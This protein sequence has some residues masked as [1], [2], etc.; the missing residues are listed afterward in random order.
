MLSLVKGLDYEEATAMGLAGCALALSRKHFRR[1]SSLWDQR[2]SPGWLAAIALVLAG[3]TWLGFFAHKHVEYSSELWWRFEFSG[4]AP[5][6]LRASVGIAALVT[7][8]GL[9]RLFRTARHPPPTG[10]ADDINAALA[11]AACAPVTGANLVALG[12]KALLFSA[13]RRSFLMYGVTGRC[14]VALGDPIG[15]ADQAEELVWEFRERCDEAG[16]WTVF[17]EVSAARLPLYVDLGLSLFKLGEEARVPLTAFSL[18]GGARKGL[19]KTR[20]RVESEGCSFAVWEP[21]EVRSRLAELAVVSEAWLRQ[22]NTREKGFSLGFFDPAYVG[23]FPAGVVL[24]Q[25]CPVAFATLWRSGGK[26]ES[27]VD[28]MRHLPDAPAG[29]MDYLFIHLILLAKEE[30]FR[31]FNL[32]MAPFSG[33]EQ[34]PLAPFWNRMGALL[35]R[36]GEHFYNFRGLRQYKEKFDPVWEPKYLASPGGLILPRVLANIGALV[37]GGLSGLIRK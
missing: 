26:E 5:R 6:F 20:S 11:I 16:V 12:D 25:G 9:S 19:R 13:S 4:N 15:A 3:T 24:R 28:L 36:H 18:E 7:V 33:I 21:E 35:F 17:Y 32:G 37:S 10:A 31:W 14:W 30:G 27:S 22:H 8:I 1:R 29:A 23:R 34:H 2:F